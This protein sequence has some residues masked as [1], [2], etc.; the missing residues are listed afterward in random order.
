MEAT[1][2]TPANEWHEW[3]EAIDSDGNHF[4]DANATRSVDIY[5]VVIESVSAAKKLFMGQIAYG[6][7]KVIIAEDRFMIDAISK[8]GS[9]VIM[10][11]N[12]LRVPA[13]QTL[14]GRLKCEVPAATADIS[15][16]Y[17]YA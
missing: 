15:L 12:A 14:Y 5:G 1:A 10:L 4:A 7:D 3:E 9:M 2:G 8:S 6:D 11:I 17:N 13:G 16:L